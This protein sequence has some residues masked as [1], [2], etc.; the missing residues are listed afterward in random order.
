MVTLEKHPQSPLLELSKA[1]IASL[2]STL[3]NSLQ[4][5]AD[6]HAKLQKTKQDLKDARSLNLKLADYK[7][8][9]R[10]AELGYEVGY[11]EG[12]KDVC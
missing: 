10:K 2:K 6:L 5:N 12:A 9:R 7:E 3:A 4:D 8:W 1:Y 11:S